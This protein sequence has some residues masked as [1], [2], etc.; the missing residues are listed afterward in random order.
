MLSFV[1]HND[2]VRMSD[3]IRRDGKVVDDQ[4]TLVIIYPC[5]EM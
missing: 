3:F 2:D 1:R 5:A 4:D